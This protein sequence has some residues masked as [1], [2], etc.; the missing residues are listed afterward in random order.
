M[1]CN[2]RKDTLFGSL[3]HVSCAEGEAMKDELA[4]LECRLA[5]MLQ[6]LDQVVTTTTTTRTSTAGMTVTPSLKLVDGSIGLIDHMTLGQSLAIANGINIAMLPVPTVA[7]NGFPLDKSAE[8]YRAQCFKEP[9][10]M[11]ACS[12]RSRALA[13]ADVYVISE[14]Q[15]LGITINLPESAT[16]AKKNDYMITSDDVVLKASAI[17][18]QLQNAKKRL[19]SSEEANAAV[20]A[21]KDSAAAAAKAAAEKAGADAKAKGLDEA[22]QAA[23][24]AKAEADAASAAAV[25]TAAAVAAKPKFG[26]RTT[27]LGATLTTPSGMT[28]YFVSATPKDQAGCDAP[29]GC[30]DFWTPVAAGPIAGTGVTCIIGTFRRTDTGQDQATCN[31]ALL[32]TFNADS[33]PGD[34]TGQGQA[35]FV[36]AK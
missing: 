22:A 1:P 20:Q 34:T 10:L 17:V 33:K 25:A 15:K 28:M 36:I 2:R 4:T 24:R 5:T 3:T 6:A 29:S 12:A 21:A 32:Y 23:A 8:Y 7:I 19:D 30:L 14:A 18:M 9:T 26:S 31:G 27:S 35:G 13:V 11:L 16:V